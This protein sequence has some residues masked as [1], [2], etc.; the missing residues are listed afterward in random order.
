MLESRVQPESWW[1]CGERVVVQVQRM[2]LHQQLERSFVLDARDRVITSIEDL[3]T[4]T[5]T[6][7]LYTN[8]LTKN[9]RSC[10]CANTYL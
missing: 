10:C 3:L 4:R 7:T 1:Q 9:E 2:Q 8:E 6:L 5:H